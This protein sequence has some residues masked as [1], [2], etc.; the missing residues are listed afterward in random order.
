MYAPRDLTPRQL[1]A[2][3]AEQGLEAGLAA[4]NAAVPHRYTGVYR[5]RGDALHNVFLVDKEE[6]VRPDELAV[7]QLEDSFCQFVLRDGCFLTSDT[8]REP[9][10]DGHRYQGVVL[11]YHGVPVADN[12]GGL[13]GTLCHFD[14]VGREL[15][16]GQF[17]LLEAAG[18]MLFPYV[19]HLRAEAHPS[20]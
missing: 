18:K 10:L 8:A 14:M 4:L 15:P 9:L 16:A 17:E 7:V 13:F 3:L 6:A 1:R 5:L 20:A 19:R 12:A 2:S 11:S